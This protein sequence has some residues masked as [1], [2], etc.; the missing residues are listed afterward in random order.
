MAL[1][2]QNSFHLG[3]ISL[4][5]G[6]HYG[7]VPT[8]SWDQFGRTWERKIMGERTWEIEDASGKRRVT[9][10]QFRAEIDARKAAAAPIMAAWKRGDVDGCAK[11]QAEMRARF[12]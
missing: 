12:R 7:N 5:F 3:N 10:A 11:A 1:P 6:C 8:V 4:A 9:L 2:Y